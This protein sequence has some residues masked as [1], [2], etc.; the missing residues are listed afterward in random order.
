[1]P[2]TIIIRINNEECARSCLAA[3]AKD[4]ARCF[5]PE[6]S[7]HPNKVTITYRTPEDEA[8]AIAGD[9]NF[10]EYSCTWTQP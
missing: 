4:L 6:A 10:K 1:M 8:K 3:G 9:F 7:I 5:L 2:A